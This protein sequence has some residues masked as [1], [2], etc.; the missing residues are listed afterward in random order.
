MNMIAFYLQKN[1]HN[2]TSNA[3]IE[4]TFLQMAGPKSKSLAVK[5]T[6]IVSAHIYEY[7]LFYYSSSSLGK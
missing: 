1:P 6:I 2:C 3:C 7:Y 5:T 4:I